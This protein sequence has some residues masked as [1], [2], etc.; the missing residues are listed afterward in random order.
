MNTI[1]G[2]ILLD[3]AISPLVRHGI[4]AA[5][6]YMIAQ[7]HADPEAISAV[8]GGGVAAVGIA[9]SWLEKKLRF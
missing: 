9:L 3:K 2:T 7:G 8:A 6:G 1:I 4:T 5:G